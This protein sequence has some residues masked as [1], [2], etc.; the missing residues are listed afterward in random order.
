MHKCSNDQV[1]QTEIIVMLIIQLLWFIFTAMT[2]K[3]D[4]EWNVGAWKKYREELQLHDG[5]SESLLHICG[6]SL[7]P[8]VV[9]TVLMV[10]TRVVKERRRGRSNR[11][12][13]LR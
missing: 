11:G 10:L 4:K 12:L 5:L 2:W 9:G 3:L 8:K 1:G 7:V 13:L 6:A